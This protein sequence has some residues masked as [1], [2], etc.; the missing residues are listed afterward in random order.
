VRIFIGYDRR[1]P[2]AFHVLCSSLLRRASAP[3]SITPLCQD[4]LRKQGVYT[5][6]RTA[7]ESTD[8]TLTRF[9]VPYL[10]GYQGRALFMD[11]DILCQTD[12]CTLSPDGEADVWVAQHDYAPRSATKFLGQA[13]APYPRKNWS[14]VMLFDNARCQALTPEYVNTATPAQLHRFEWAGRIGELE[15][16]W[17]WLVG[18][19]ALNDYAKLL[20]YTNGGPWFDGYQACDHAKNWWME[21]QAMQE[22]L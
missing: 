21:L 1:E 19:Y 8:F 11:C 20:H 9:L 12:I 4:A 3:L 22:P 10:C 15:L 5:R 18:E 16:D 6:E 13:Q 7:S 2:I 17:N 14:S